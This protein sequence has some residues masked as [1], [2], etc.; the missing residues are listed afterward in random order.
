MSKVKIN[1]IESLTTTSPN[2]GDLTITPNGT[3]VFE[4]AGEDDS[5]ILA[6][7]TATQSNKV[8]IKPP[9]TAQ[10]YTMVLPT[11][12][13]DLSTNKILKVD[14][15]TGS[16]STAVGQL[17]YT[18]LPAQD[19]ANLNASNVSTGTVNNARLPS[20]LPAS[21]GSGFKL[22]STTTVPSGSPVNGISWDLDSDSLYK[23]ISNNMYFGYSWGGSTTWSGMDIYVYRVS[24]PYQYSQSMSYT[25]YKAGTAELAQYAAG[26]SQAQ[27][28]YVAAY[29]KNIYDG[30]S[31][32][33]QLVIELST[34]NENSW[35]YS[36]IR[37][38]AHS[39]VQES[40]FSELRSSIDD[41]QS[42]TKQFDRIRLEPSGSYFMYSSNLSQPTEFRLYKYMES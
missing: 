4:V 40:N 19:G 33:A 30:V 39:G 16:G 26:E 9:S 10:D 6:L 35:I 21:T 24:S 18:D 41:Q 14:S 38:R 36:K 27:S 8:K 12:D 15:I 17:A 20:P 37:D 23:I 42:G 1:E 5:G 32:V 34:V 28:S 22:I 25:G 13:I 7:N 31:D 29:T 11:T 3:G 2:N